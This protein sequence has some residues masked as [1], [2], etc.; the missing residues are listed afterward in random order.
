MATRGEAMKYLRGING[1]KEGDDGLFS[2]VIKWADDGRSQLVFLRVVDEFII[3]TSAFAHKDDISTH[4]A[5][6]LAM[7]FGVTDMGDHYGLRHVIFLE[8]LDESE[9]INGIKWLGARA[10]ILESKVG[11][12]AL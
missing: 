9:I 12:D 1:M 8:D 2:Y 6:D 11:G 7:I 3:L 10:D 4:K 5:L